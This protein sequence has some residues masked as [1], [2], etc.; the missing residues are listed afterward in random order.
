LSRQ[1]TLRVRPGTGVHSFDG[2]VHY[3]AGD[4]FTI[5]FSEAAVCLRGKGRRSFEIVEVYDDD[6][7]SGERNDQ[8]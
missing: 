6:E 3:T 8:P 2:R 7:L 1:I 5:P 4:E